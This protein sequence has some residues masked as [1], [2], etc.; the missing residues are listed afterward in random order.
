M[1]KTT[2]L[3]A[4]TLFTAQ[5]FAHEDDAKVAGQMVG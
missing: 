3:I 5:V 1:Y 4:A 2:T